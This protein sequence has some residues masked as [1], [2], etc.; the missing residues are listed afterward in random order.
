MKLLSKRFVT[1]LPLF[2]LL[3]C[4]KD[5]NH[6]NEGKPSSYDGSYFSKESIIGNTNQEDFSIENGLF[7]SKNITGSINERT[8]KLVSDR[9][10]Y[11]VEYSEGELTLFDQEEKPVLTGY[12]QNTSSFDHIDNIYGTYF[13][14]IVPKYQD[15]VREHETELKEGAYKNTNF[16]SFVKSISI[17]DDRLTIN[18]RDEG[19]IKNITIQLEEILLDEPH[20]GYDD[21]E[22]IDTQII[23]NYLSGQT[24]TDLIVLTGFSMKYNLGGSD[25]EYLILHFTKN[26]DEDELSP[27]ID[28][29]LISKSLLKNEIVDDTFEKNSDG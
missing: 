16:N 11:K 19:E 12:K 10:K 4:V 25:E 17:V 27:M 13:Q 22:A 29:T 9:K 6:S 15:I 7:T 5:S 26:N 21:E 20:L 14:E 18:H 28:V 3:G 8:M 23:E 24:I 1:V 2:L